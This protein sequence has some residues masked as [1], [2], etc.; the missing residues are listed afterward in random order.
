VSLIFHRHNKG[1]L[2]VVI[3]STICQESRVQR[4]REQS[5]KAKRAEFKLL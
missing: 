4:P 3:L 2:F 5:S 1:M